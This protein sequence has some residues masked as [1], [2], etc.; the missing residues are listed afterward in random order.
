M[1]HL[2]KRSISVALILMLVLTTGFNQ[3]IKAD[4]ALY[5][6]SFTV[7]KVSNNGTIHML[8]DDHRNYLNFTLSGDNLF[9]AK[10]N[11]T[12]EYRIEGAKA[13]R[14][15]EK[16][17]L[18]NG[19]SI[20]TLTFENDTLTIVFNENVE[21]LNH[22]TYE[23]NLSLHNL[24]EDGFANEGD[25]EVFK[26]PDKLYSVHIIRD[27]EYP[28]I[29]DN[30]PIHGYNG[31]RIAFQHQTSG[32]QGQGGLYSYSKGYLNGDFSSMENTRL[33]F[34][35]IKSTQPE[36]NVYD[37]DLTYRPTP[38]HWNTNEQNDIFKSIMG[39]VWQR[40][41]N[42][43][44]DPNDTNS[45]PYIYTRVITNYNF[46]TWLKN[47]AKS[48]TI[49][50]N[51]MEIDLG[52]ILSKGTKDLPGPLSIEWEDITT[53]LSTTVVNGQTTVI[54]ATIQATV[55]TDDPAKQLVGHTMHKGAEQ[56][57]RL[58]P[59]QN[60][61]GTGFGIKV[62]K[63]DNDGNPMPNIQFSVV[64]IK[65]KNGVNDGASAGVYTTDANG[66]FTTKSNLSDLDEYTLVELNKPP[67]YLYEELI[68]DGSNLVNLAELDETDIEAL[69][70]V[71]IYNFTAPKNNQGS[72]TARYV[73]TLGEEIHTPIHSVGDH[74]SPYTTSVLDIDGYE[75]IYIDDL[76]DPANGLYVA[77]SHFE[78]VYVYDVKEPE[79][80]TDPE[81]PTNPEVPTDPETPTNPE[82][83]TQPEKPTPPAK[84]ETLPS[85]GVGSVLPLGLIS[86]GL[87]LAIVTFRLRKED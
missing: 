66:M 70:P 40:S 24:I 52:D 35:I 86:T 16:E 80:P 77:N 25:I 9:N 19:I 81:V 58:S 41:D 4:T 17:I 45:N 60:A 75:F 44:Y 74:D 27:V 10:A 1:K 67:H 48:F 18:I 54:P 50:D 26:G 55:T 49:V 15:Q 42:P 33:T 21:Y 62:Q 83:P 68:I 36:H 31:N 64:R 28:P 85:T 5:N 37:Y 63:L 32:V 76:S 73:N 38:N 84:E 29:S 82:V 34:E 51:K 69:K 56:S 57:Y 59:D 8:E 14:L 12:L 23:T 22:F 6:A 46:S 2:L 43:S 3:S 20:G 13:T 30:P 78:V 61:S 65:N 79:V 87:G 53:Y 7:D 39:Y 11:D 71:K 47:N 72:V